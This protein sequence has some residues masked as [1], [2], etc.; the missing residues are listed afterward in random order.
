MFYLD[1]YGVDVSFIMGFYNWLTMYVF[2]WL[3]V[4]VILII[5]VLVSVCNYVI[6]MI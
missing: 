2:L 3:T 4:Y 6:T 5:T 1:M